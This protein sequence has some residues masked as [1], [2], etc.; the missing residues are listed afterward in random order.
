MQPVVRLRRR[1]VEAVRPP[2][3]SARLR[4]GARGGGPLGGGEP[5]GQVL[6]GLPH[7]PQAVQLVEHGDAV[8]SL[9][10]VLVGPLDEA[11]VG[12]QQVHPEHVVL[13]AQAHVVRVLGKG[14]LARARDRQAGARPRGRRRAAP[15][16]RHD[17]RGEGVRRD[18]EDHGEDDQQRDPEARRLGPPVDRGPECVI[19]HLLWCK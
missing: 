19:R 8:L 1:L 12:R 11:P 5:L 10:V 18:G 4:A 16:E 13:V 2:G 15:E 6:H 9:D 14:H 17:R 7:H 3:V